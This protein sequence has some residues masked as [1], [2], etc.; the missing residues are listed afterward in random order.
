M[1]SH[2][3]PLQ[4]IATVQMRGAVQMLLAIHREMG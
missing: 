2:T 4:T 1:V 3:L